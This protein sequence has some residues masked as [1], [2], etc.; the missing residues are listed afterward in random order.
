ME[1]A[2]ERRGAGAR[3]APGAAARVPARALGLRP[4]RAGLSAAF[5][6]PVFGPVGLPQGMS[7]FNKNVTLRLQ[8]FAV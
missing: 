1:R 8:L 4:A 2:A 6:E 7:N 3:A 5:R